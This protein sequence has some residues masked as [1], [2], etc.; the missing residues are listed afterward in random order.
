MVSLPDE[1]L[2][3]LD[4]EAAR[5]GITR[6]GLLRELAEQRIRERSRSRRERIRA[7]HRSE[8]R[9]GY[10]GRVSEVLKASRPAR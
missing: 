10:G 9:A 3:A 2:S 5:L 1:L 8:G 7:M 6:S 4:I